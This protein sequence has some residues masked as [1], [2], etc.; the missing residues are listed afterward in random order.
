M[1][2]FQNKAVEALQRQ[3]EAFS[4]LL[5]KINKRLFQ[6][7]SKEDETHKSLDTIVNRLQKIE[8]HQKESILQLEEISDFLQSEDNER[9]LVDS[10]IMTIDII[11]DF[12]RFAA[13]EDSPYF[14][15]A[16]MM[17]NAAMKIASKTKLTVID[18]TG[19]PVD[20]QRHE[21]GGVA[22]DESLSNGVIIETLKCGYIYKSE[23]IR[24]ATVIVNKL[25]DRQASKIVLL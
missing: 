8:T 25:P 1:K 24:R 11:E 23:V 9:V 22:A 20:F 21:A 16:K 2:I 14:E 13:S 17:W 18:E 6:I 5:I 19:I 12:Y 10:V 7:E 3:R 15:Q 4:E